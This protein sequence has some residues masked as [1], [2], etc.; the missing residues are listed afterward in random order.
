MTKY[1]TTIAFLFITSYSIAQSITDQELNKLSLTYAKTSFDELVDLLSLPNDAHFPKDIEKNFKWCKKAFTD[2]GFSTQQLTTKKIPLLLASKNYKKAKKTVLVYLQV[3]GQPVDT[4]KW[5]QDN[6]Y[7]AT[8]KEFNDQDKSW[9]TISLSQLKD[10]I[11]PDWRIFARST[12][13]AKGPVVMFLK[14]MDIINDLNY[15]PNFN[16]KVIMDFEEEISSPRLPKAVL[17]YKDQLASDMLVIFDGPMHISNKPT[18]AYGA[19]GITTLSLEVFGPRA[20][21]HSGHYGNYVPNPALRLSQLLASMVQDDGRVAIP[22]WYDGIEISEETKKILNQVPD[23]E[24]TMRK[25]LGIASI[26]NIAETYQESIQ[27]PS[28]GILGIKSGWVGTKRRTIIPSSAIAE[29]NIRLVKETNAKHMVDLVKNHII[30][31]GYHII[32]SIPTEEER[33]KYKKIIRFNHQI[34][35]DAFRTDFNTEIG[36]WLRNAI[37]RAFGKSPI[38]IRTGGG[39][40]PISPFV[41]TLN[42]PA[43]IVPTV[44][45]D[46]N[47]HS[48]NENIRVGNYID[49]IKTITAILTQKL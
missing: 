1:L 19:R 4:T 11:N 43:V 12:S 32:D 36:Q 44:N 40:I 29:M 39:S 41:N 18:L 45:K 28:L 22:G 8:L 38:Q 16:I 42:I 25:K 3:D 34:A 17:D 10:T 21:Q 35:Y 33:M 46:N 31:Q 23:D 49:G 2:R 24:Q 14:A 27:Y 7:R 37:T 20:P 5:F 9:N 30:N 47:Q 48:P 26:D 15:E 6:P 13:D